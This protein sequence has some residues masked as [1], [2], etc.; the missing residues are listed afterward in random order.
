M[1][2]IQQEFGNEQRWVNWKYIDKKDGK[3]PTKVPFNPYTGECAKS[4]D[5][6]T[7]SDYNTARSKSDKIGL[8]L[9][10]EAGNIIGIDFDKILSDETLLNNAKAFLNKANTYTEVS[11]S[12]NGLRAFLKTETPYKLLKNKEGIGATFEVYNT[13]RFLTVTELPYENYNRPIRTV[14]HEELTSILEMQG[15]PW[16]KTE[17][18]S[19]PVLNYSTSSTL[20]DQ[21]VLDIMFKS[22]NGAKIKQIYDT[23]Q[24]DGVS[25]LDASLCSHLAF[26]CGG[27]FDQ[28]ERIW[29]LSPL[30]SRK[31][32]QDI[33]GYRKRTIDKSISLCKEFYKPSE[34]TIVKKEFVENMKEDELELLY[35]L[36]KEKEKVTVVNTENIVRVLKYHPEFKGKLR[37][38][39]FKNTLEIYRNDKWEEMLDHE[40][41]NIQTR[42]SVLFPSFLKVSKTMVEDALNKVIHDNEIRSVPDFIK[43]L[44]WDGVSRLDSWLTYA[45]GTANDEYHKSVGSNWMKGMVNRAINPGSKF[46]N[47]LVLEGKQGLKKSLALSTLGNIN[48]MINHLETTMSAGNKDFFMSFVGKLIVEFSEGETL[49]RSETKQL[50]GIITTAYD[51][52]R[53][54]YARKSKDHPRWCVFAMTTNEDTYLKDDTGNRRWL[55]VKVLLDECNIK[56][57]EENRE[58]LYAEAYHRVINLKET[59]WEFPK[60]L[61]EEAQDE[62]RVEDINADKVVEWY[63]T[64][65]FP[66]ERE[67][68]ITI[69]EVYD[70][71]ISEVDSVPFTPYEAI[72]IAGILKGS[73]KLTLKRKNESNSKVNKWFDVQN[74]HNSISVK[75]EEE[76]KEVKERDNPYGDEF[77]DEVIN[78]VSTQ[79]EK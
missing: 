28:I 9:G 59:Y 46:D 4:N 34:R 42:I 66:Y 57:I 52:Y 45:F 63:T 62:R 30:G 24:D 73:L 21:Q 29:V 49:T 78:N 74:R 47:V 22:K 54:P 31:K 25:E 50:K 51:N 76:K 75:P 56:W 17:E 11:P 18:I 1:S 33:S 37:Y 70:K 68:G 55:P 32:T 16:G 41:I 5:S 43:S 3:K 20:T 69:R 19:R 10:T 6:S 12:G 64:K 40:S 71:V 65:L 27:N 53:E 44:K 79:W 23:I 72:R 61:L 26:Y 7:W 35:V 77:V 15:Y 14:S 39:K 67:Q 2:Y 60:E 48:E 58:Q 36:N 38:D 13:V 8:Q